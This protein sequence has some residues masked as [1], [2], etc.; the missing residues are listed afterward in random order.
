MST[1]AKKSLGQHFLRSTH[2]LNKMVEAAN[3]TPG[4]IVLEI[5]PGKGA[6][7]EKLVQAG[8]RVIAVEKDD[9]CIG[10][11]DE[12][13]AHLK[14]EE[15]PIIIHGDIL[16]ENI[17]RTIFD[18]KHLGARPYKLVANIP[19]YITGALFRLFLENLRQPTSLTFLIQKEVA[20]QIVSRG[21]KEGILSLSIKAYGEPRYAGKVSRDAFSPPPKVDSA[22]IHIA[23]ISRNKLGK[24][25]DEDFFRVL[26]AGFRARRKKLLGNL[27]DGLSLSKITLS[28]IFLELGISVDIRGED[29]ALPEWVALAKRLS[30]K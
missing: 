4:D 19:Y 15:R 30:Q 9:R 17:Q 21:G 22:I 23:D 28:E 10:L 7:T 12:T 6:L 24:L 20:E 25:S 13:F 27:S 26:K 14:K 11:L 29:L 8:A 3:I 5:G 16:D 1:F 2:A 18:A